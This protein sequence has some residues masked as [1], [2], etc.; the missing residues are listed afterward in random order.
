MI[1]NDPR[2][3]ACGSEQVGQDGAREFIINLEVERPLL[4]QALD[5]ARYV[6]SQPDE[7]IDLVA[8]PA[9]RYE[10]APIHLQANLFEARELLLSEG[11][12]ALYVRRPS[13]PMSFRTCGVLR[14]EEVASAYEFRR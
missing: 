5:L 2:S 13:A 10:R 6:E 14:R 9:E 7:D 12:D 11:A 3:R 8:I 1:E 4:L